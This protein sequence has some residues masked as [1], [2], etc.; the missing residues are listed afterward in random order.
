MKRIKL[1]I[2]YDGTNF[3]GWQ[4]QPGKR[5]IQGEIE[6]AIRIIYGKG[7]RIEG[8]GRTDRGVHAYGQ[9][10]SFSVPEK[11]KNIELLRAI[12]GNTGNDILVKECV[13]VPEDFHAR[14]SAKSRIYQYRIYNGKSVFSR[15][16]F[17]QTN[18]RLDMKSMKNAAKRLIGKKDFRNLATKD[19]GICD[20]MRIDI[21][22]KEDIVYIIVESDRFL[23][24]MV[25]GIVG[26]ILSAG[27]GA[28]HPEEINEV[29]AGKIRRPGVLSPQGLFLMK[30][31]Y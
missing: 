11:F 14:K 15:R 4:V 3:Y 28:L 23:R 17:Y 9:V 30:V 20:L 27:E 10:A 21:S 1:T 29:V 13:E 19:Q 16:Y 26:V 24:R 18:K 25:R 12:N 2:E 6:E 31:V 5:T 8:A 7:I 22:N